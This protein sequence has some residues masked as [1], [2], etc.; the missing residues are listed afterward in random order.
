M[1]V[2]STDEQQRYQIA[3]LTA[4]DPIY[5]HKSL[6]DILLVTSDQ[7]GFFVPRSFLVKHSGFFADLE[8]LFLKERGVSFGPEQ[9]LKSAEDDVAVRELPSASSLPLHLILDTFRAMETI[10]AEQLQAS[11][12]VKSSRGYHLLW[13]MVDIQEAFPQ[14]L[15]IADAYQFDKFAVALVQC[16]PESIWS[17]FLRAVMSLDEQRVKKATAKLLPTRMRSIPLEAKLILQLHAP[18]Y[19]TR[20]R[21]LQSLFDREVERLRSCWMKEIVSDIQFL[22]KSCH[23]DSTK[24]HNVPGMLYQSGESCTSNV[25]MHGSAAVEAAFQE[26]QERDDGDEGLWPAIQERLSKL[27]V[28][29]QCQQN[30]YQTLHRTW[31]R[32]MHEWRPRSSRNM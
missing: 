15:E 1:S 25:E 2:T 20:I 31:N 9:G 10:D 5:V 22:P 24:S 21:L 14:A 13:P 3:N 19:L 30:L 6:E 7:V 29:K 16:L 8:N 27:L 4:I 32:Y 26:F 17:S 28:C 12:K 18:A 11:P 23:N